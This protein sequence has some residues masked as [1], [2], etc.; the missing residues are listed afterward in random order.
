V[1]RDVIAGRGPVVLDPVEDDDAFGHTP[2]GAPILAAARARSLVSV[3]IPGPVA[4]GPVAGVLTVIRRDGRRGFALA[5]AALF[6][7]IAAHLSIT[8]ANQGLFD[9]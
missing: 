7:G 1:V 2:S 9:G 8:L 6:T 4:D 3:A 5:D